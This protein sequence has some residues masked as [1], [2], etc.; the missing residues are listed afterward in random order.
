MKLRKALAKA[1]K[2]RQEVIKLNVT[3]TQPEDPGHL[4]KK[5]G[6]G[7]KPPVY[8]Q[9]IHIELDTEV[10]L[11][12]RCICVEPNS[13]EIDCYKVLRT[14][15][16]Q[17]TQAKGWNTVMITSTV[18]GEGKTLTSINLALTFSKAYNQTVLLVDCDLRYQSI[19]K[20]L[21]FHNDSGLIECLMDNR[22]LQESIIWPGIEKLTLMS[23]GRTIQDS[24]ELLGSP[25]MQALVKEMK[26]RYD[27][28]Y[29]IFDLPPL[30]VGADALALA[31]FI[32]CIVMVV[33]EGRTPT[34]DLQK[35]MQ[36]LPP[37]KFIGFVMN[38]QK[39][40]MAEY[41]GAYY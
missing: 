41:Y 19:H 2:A 11:R 21:G 34:K 31:P 6:N 1:K 10:L 32:D 20:V 18:P 36:M 39:I 38:R 3:K 15:I 35:A 12:N 26:T 4:G 8:S 37:E 7:W 13:P 17:L 9:S 30:L 22:P 16:Q 14:K 25:R 23:G 24:T 29:V 33:E 5:P 40:A 28:R 27:D